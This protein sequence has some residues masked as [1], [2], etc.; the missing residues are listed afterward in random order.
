M[1]CPFTNEPCRECALYRGRHYYLCFCKN[2]RGHLDES[3]EASKTSV[4]SN[5]KAIP[6]NTFKMPT[7]KS[8]KAIDPFE[9]TLND[10]F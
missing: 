9:K 7:I 10:S 4:S 5:F 6:S 2:Y 8:T 3:E 1:I